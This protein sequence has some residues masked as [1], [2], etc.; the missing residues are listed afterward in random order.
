MPL[1]ETVVHVDYEQ[2]CIGSASC[3]PRLTEEKQLCAKEFSFSFRLLPVFT[4][5]VMPFEK[6]K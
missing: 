6:L 3:G 4:N 1:E 2:S 5:N